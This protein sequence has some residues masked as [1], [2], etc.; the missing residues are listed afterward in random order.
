[1][2]LTAPLSSTVSIS[3]KNNIHSYDDDVTAHAGFK[4]DGSYVKYGENGSWN[5]SVNPSDPTKL[6]ATPVL[7]EESI[8]EKHSLTL[9][10]YIDANFFLFDVPAG[11]TVS[12]SWGEDAD[13]GDAPFTATDTTFT[14]QD[15]YKK[16]SVS[17]A[18]KEI[19]DDITV[20]LIYNN[21]VVASETYK[22]SDYLY[23]VIGMNKSDLAAEI[24]KTQAKA[25]QL[26]TL[27]KATLDYC[28]KA[29]I[30]FGYHTDSL[31]D[32][33]LSY[34]YD[35]VDTDGL[36]SYSIEGDSY[37]DLS[38][39][40]LSGQ[41]YDYYGQSLTLESGTDYNII[42]RNRTGMPLT[43]TAVDAADDSVTYT[44][45]RRVLNGAA[46]GTDGI[47]D[48]VTFDIRNIPAAKLSDD[49]VFTFAGGITVTV[50]PATYM[51]AAMYT[52]DYYQAQYPVYAERLRNVVAALYNYNQVAVDYFAD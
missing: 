50:N 17:L 33:A 16:T 3:D 34:S 19:N 46:V 49:I 35:Q 13:N 48:Y 26:Q 36:S 15:G 42:F 4:A 6:T 9:E 7:E 12:Y 41:G 52:A 18:A 51:H 2:T 10:G 37:D 32:S 29:Q 44:V 45:R 47:G 40:S 22:A 8:F 39:L 20:N 28:A 23:T 5:Y 14:N 43:A 21:N 11:A 27:C 38:Y 24:G 25:A 31:A 1:M 30:Q